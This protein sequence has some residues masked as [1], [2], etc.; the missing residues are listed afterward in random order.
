MRLQRSIVPPGMLIAA[1]RPLMNM[2]GPR[3]QFFTLY[4]TE[5]FDAFSRLSDCDRPV[6]GTDALDGL[7][8]MV[9]TTSGDRVAFEHSNRRRQ[10]LDCHGITCVS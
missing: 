10:T 1:L 6:D 5:H 2:I 4:G 3:S 9:V 8:L 7:S